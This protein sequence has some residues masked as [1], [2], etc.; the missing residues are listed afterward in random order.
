MLTNFEI[1]FKNFEKIFEFQIK[2]CIHYFISIHVQWHQHFHL[3]FIN[4]KS[5]MSIIHFKIVFIGDPE[6]KI[7]A[8]EKEEDE[9]QEQEPTKRIITFSDT[10]LDSGLN[11]AATIK[12]L[13]ENDLPLPSEIKNDTYK[14]IK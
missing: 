7:L 3:G 4:V 10:D 6:L 8:V 14:T 1:T 13:K 9:K 2:I 5:F 12:F 11:N